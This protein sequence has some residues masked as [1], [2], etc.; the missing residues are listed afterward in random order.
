VD[1]SKWRS[2]GCGCCGPYVPPVF[3]DCTCFAGFTT[4]CSIFGGISP[5]S[6]CT[7]VII[8]VLSISPGATPTSDL[9]AYR[10]LLHNKGFLAAARDVGHSDPFCNCFL[11]GPSAEFGATFLGI[12]PHPNSAVDVNDTPHVRACLADP[13]VTGGLTN[14]RS[15]G[16]NDGVNCGQSVTSIGFKYNFLGGLTITF[17]PLKPIPPRTDCTTGTPAPV[18]SFFQPTYME[19]QESSCDPFLVDE[20][21]DMVAFFAGLPLQLEPCYMSDDGTRY[22]NAGQHTA[23]LRIRVVATE[24]IP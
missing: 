18:T 17:L 9:D 5:L 16:N 1:H 6:R 24:Y 20:E 22:L 3:P 15:T 21:I 11:G 14:Y 4:D 12:H 19:I 13:N 10:C 7:Q 2:L 8:Q 23:T